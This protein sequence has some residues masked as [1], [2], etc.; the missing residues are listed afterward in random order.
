MNVRK[1]FLVSLDFNIQKCLL[2]NFTVNIN[3]YHLNE[4]YNF[5]TVYKDLNL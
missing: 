2:T 4:T 1:S 5:I 3:Y